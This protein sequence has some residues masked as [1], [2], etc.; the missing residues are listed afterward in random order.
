MTRR[1]EGRLNAMLALFYAGISTVWIVELARHPK[2]W[3]AWDT[4][5]LTTCLV[6]AM[7]F[8]VIATIHFKGKARS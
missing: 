8:T 5:G 7:A 2:E 4:V 6:S 3:G 1:T